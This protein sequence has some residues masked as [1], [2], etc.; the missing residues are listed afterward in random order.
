MSIILIKN[1]KQETKQTKPSLR[2]T[3]N[4]GKS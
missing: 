1:K 3:P 4:Y 2:K